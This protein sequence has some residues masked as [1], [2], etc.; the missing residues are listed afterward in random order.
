MPY[1]KLYRNQGFVTSNTNKYITLNQGIYDY[2]Y[3]KNH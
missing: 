2:N 1:V 3:F